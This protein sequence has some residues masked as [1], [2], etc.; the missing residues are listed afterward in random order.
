MRKKVAFVVIGS[1]LLAVLAT[2]VSFAA[3][4]AMLGVGRVM[5][6]A[7]AEFAAHVGQTEYLPDGQPVGSLSMRCHENAGGGTRATCRARGAGALRR[8]AAA[9]R[10]GA[11]LGTSGAAPSGQGDCAPMSELAHPLPP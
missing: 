10:V 5:C 11:H 1:L 8:L 9:L 3:A 7:D 6:G 4:P 2:A